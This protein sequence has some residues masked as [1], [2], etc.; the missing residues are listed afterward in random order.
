MG[1]H[2]AAADLLSARP[3]EIAFGANMTTLTLAVSRALA[4][5]WAA[6]DELVVTRLDH[7]ANVAP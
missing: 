7:D 2:R 3:E 4:R 1:A 5:N 6:G